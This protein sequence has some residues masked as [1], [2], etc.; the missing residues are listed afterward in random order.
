MTSVK[1]CL[2]FGVVGGSDMSALII[3]TG[4]EKRIVTGG[5]ATALPI[6]GCTNSQL[7]QG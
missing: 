2:P 1:H 3:R 5:E 6:P 4:K 7:L